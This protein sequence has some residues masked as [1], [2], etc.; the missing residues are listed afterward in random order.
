MM[1]IKAGYEV[2]NDS[3][4]HIIIHND[5]P[6]GVLLDSIVSPEITLFLWNTLKE[7]DM[8]KTEMLD[9]LISKFD[10]STVLALGNIDIFVRILKENGIIEE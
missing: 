5:M 2:E 1:R 10:V 6:T 3:G 8:T 9:A 7:R 4:Q